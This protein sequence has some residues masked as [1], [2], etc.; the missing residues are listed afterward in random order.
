VLFIPA[1]F[2]VGVYGMN[3]DRSFPLNMPELGWP[4]GYLAIMSMMALSMIAT[5]AYFKRKKWF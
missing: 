2:I 4:Y 5:I 3:F 1:T